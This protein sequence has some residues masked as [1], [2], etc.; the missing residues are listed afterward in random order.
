[1]TQ[2][3]TSRPNERSP[4]VQ[5][6]EM[7]SSAE[8]ALLAA[9]VTTLENLLFIL[10]ASDLVTDLAVGANKAYLVAPFALT[11]V[12]VR[13]T[14]LVAPTGAALQVDIN[15]GVSSILSTKLT[16]DA[17]ETDSANAAVPAVISDSAIA[18]GAIISVDIDVVGSVVA[19][20]GLMIQLVCTRV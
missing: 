14:V 11:V 8:H 2:V 9:R 5:H 12:S 3:L 18:S 15:D 13:A 10:S 17:D 19:G 1:M 6:E 16:I 7:A 20:K 4:A